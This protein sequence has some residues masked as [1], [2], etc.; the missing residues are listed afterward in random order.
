VSPS[1]ASLDGNGSAYSIQSIP[2]PA[3]MSRVIPLRTEFGQS[4]SY[5]LHLQAS[6]WPSTSPIFLEDR[7]LQ[8]I[9]TIFGPSSYHFF[10]NGPADS[11]R[12]RIHLNSVGV[13]VEVH[14]LSDVHVFYHS[15]MLHLRG[16]EALRRMEIRDM[17]GRLVQIG[18]PEGQ[19]EIHLPLVLA[20]GIYSVHLF[21]KSGSVTRKL[22]K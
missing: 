10:A 9:E 21:G 5:Q 12:F 4:G 17:R 20:N 22:L 16:A 15:G 1:L 3:G 6:N 8:R 7:L 11:L 13:G 2:D 14:D 19:H 18:H